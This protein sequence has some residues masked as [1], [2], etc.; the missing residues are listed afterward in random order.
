MDSYCSVQFALREEIRGLLVLVDQD[1]DYQRVEK[2]I[3]SRIGYLT[4]YDGS[5]NHMLH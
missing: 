2:M 4:T 3:T 1:D 5:A